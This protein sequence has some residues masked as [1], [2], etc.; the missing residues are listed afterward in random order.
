[1]DK[2]PGTRARIPPRSRAHI[3]ARAVEKPRIPRKELAKK[4]QKELEKQGF[5]VPEIEVLERMISEYRNKIIDGPEDKPWSLLTLAKYDIAAEALPTVF[6]LWVYSLKEFKK[7]L[8]I[9]EMKWAARLYRIM[10]DDI[11]GLLLFST[12]YAAYEKAYETLGDKFAPIANE[13]GFQAD[14]ELYADTLFKKTEEY[15]LTTEELLKVP[16]DPEILK[17]KRQ[18]LL[19]ELR[20]PEILEKIKELTPIL[21]VENKREAKKKEMQNERINKTERQK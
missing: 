8:T 13:A 19:E 11:E 14:T 20:N 6:E 9:R 17:R 3:I 1:M 10:Q 21:I 12:R 16:K 7:P 2:K 18:R 15:E 5:D 4:L